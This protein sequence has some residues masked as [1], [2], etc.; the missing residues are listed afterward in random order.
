MDVLRDQNWVLSVG[1]FLPLAGVLVMLFIPKA[2][3][4]LHKVIALVTAAA[5]LA[6]GIFT[7]TKF[8][9]DQADKLQF[10]AETEWIKVI[11]SG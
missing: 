6:V 9:F 2:E 5:T 1:T 3:E 10:F 8:D 4:E 7:L 11:S